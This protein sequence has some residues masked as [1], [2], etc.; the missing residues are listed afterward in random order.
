MKAREAHAAVFMSARPR[1][2]L[3]VFLAVAVSSRA[4][5]WRS[6][7]ACLRYVFEPRAVSDGMMP[8]AMFFGHCD[9]FSDLMVAKAHASKEPAPPAPVQAMQ[10]MQVLILLLENQ[11]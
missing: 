3:T 11:V 9:T 2:R 5:L 1:C 4:E 6:A 10:A 7:S 8:L